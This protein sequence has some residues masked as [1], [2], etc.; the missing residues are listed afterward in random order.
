MNVRNAA[1][2][3]SAWD[4]QGYTGDLIYVGNTVYGQ[5]GSYRFLRTGMRNLGIRYIEQTFNVAAGTVPN[6]TYKSRLTFAVRKAWFN[7]RDTATSPRPPRRHLARIEMVRPDNT[8]R[9]LWQDTTANSTYKNNTTWSRGND[10]D[11]T[12]HFNAA[13]NYRV[14][15]YVEL[16][17]DRANDNVWSDVSFDEVMIEI[18]DVTPPSAPTGLSAKV[19]S[20]KRVDLS[21]NYSTDNIKVT[22]YHVYRKKLGDVGFTRIGITNTQLVYI[23]AG[24]LANTTYD[25]YIRASDARN[26][27][28]AAGNTVQITTKLV[29]DTPPTPPQNL[30]AYANSADDVKLTWDAATDVGLGVV[31]YKVYRAPDVGGSS[32]T[33]ELV[34]QLDSNARSYGDSG[35]RARQKYWY[36][37][38][39]VDMNNLSSTPA[40]A[41]VVMPSSP[42]GFYE[43][44]EGRCAN[45]HRAHSGVVAKILIKPNS[46]LLCMTCHD[47]W[48]S[49][50]VTVPDVLSLGQN[51]VFHPIKDTDAA[52]NNKTGS[53]IGCMDCHNPHTDKIPGTNTVYPR[54]TKVTVGSTVYLQ[55]NQYCLACHGTNDRKELS[56][57]YW[58]NT[59][60]DHS[61][62]SAV[63]Y[64]TNYSLLNP[65]SGTKITCVRC[66]SEHASPN[67]RLTLANEEALCFKCHDNAAVSASTYANIL[68]EFNRQGSR[69]DIFESDQK[70]NKS[71]VE[72]VNCH[73]PHTVAN[74]LFP[75]NTTVSATSDPDN[76]LLP[77][78]GTIVDFCLRCHDNATPTAKSVFS[79][80]KLTEYVPYNVY[81]PREPITSNASGWDKRSFKESGH[82]KKGVQSCRQCHEQH[83][84]EYPRLLKLREDGFATDQKGI[85]FQCHDGSNP[86]YNAPNIRQDFV[87]F[88]R[89]NTLV[90][91]DKHVNTESLVYDPNFQRHAECWDCHDPH[92]ASPDKAKA[93][94]MVAPG[95]YYPPTPSGALKNV[96]GVG[97]TGPRPA[98]T[99]L[100]NGLLP[101][102]SSL[103][104]TKI[105]VYQYELC[106]KCHSSRSYG[107]LPSEGMT[108]VDREFN[109][110]NAAYHPVEAR[111]KT[112]NGLYVGV[113]RFNKSW[114]PDSLMFCTDCHGTDGQGVTGYVYGV[115]G[116]VYQRILKG[117][118]DVNTGTRSTN[119]ENRGNALCF[120]CHNA[121]LYTGSSFS[122][123][124]SSSNGFGGVNTGFRRGSE[125]LH[126]M[127]VEERSAGCMHCHSMIPHGSFRRH[128][129]V[130]RSD[131]I[132]VG[133]TQGITGYTPRDNGYLVGDLY[134]I[135]CC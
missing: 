115:H 96:Y 84:S 126:R 129:I 89:H 33:Y 97:F 8:S 109:V 128:L 102:D 106:Y 69:H 83:G 7:D 29:D 51:N 46:P 2:L 104:T 53:I 93:Q 54:W 72:C 101:F 26:N 40:S 134:C 79:N 125:N 90:D 135:P 73:N 124:A 57:T 64:D 18:P 35:L 112:R 20:D 131:G 76:T 38:Y 22:G 28:S 34:V 66:H 24:L 13:G 77:W 36:N 103:Y 99:S 39:A 98:W 123:N 56:T 122:N 95:V 107:P 58:K 68:A 25:Y 130:T 116:S 114:G 88:S 30:F 132:Y 121:A 81:M 118:W 117:V 86:L 80:G 37:V 108:A 1:G 5:G 91:Y 87:K 52:L 59:L 43:P 71:K 3:S 49:R 74:K 21:W 133:N 12:S 42:H 105:V 94:T 60:G 48:G 32:G 120:N 65:S 63:H 55:G 10:Y 67:P 11:I 110:A 15:L 45:C 78:T 16:E 19:V 4:P 6:V 82:W 23:D 9:T 17:N 127:H 62:S 113:D 100:N 111:G 92:S 50:F 70:A 119:T 61:S 75:N 85:C 47:G 14:R 41:T 44:T 27:L 31:A